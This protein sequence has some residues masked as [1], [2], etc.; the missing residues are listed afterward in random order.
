MGSRDEDMLKGRDERNVASLILVPTQERL[1]TDMLRL[2]RTITRP[3]GQTAKV[4]CVGMPGIGLARGLDNDILFA[5]INTYIDADC[6]A[7]GIIHT[8]AYALLKLAGL[9]T[10]GQHYHT[11][12]QGL[13]RMLY[14]TYHVT[15]GWFD[16]QEKRFITVAFR[17]IDSL[18]YT[19]KEQ[20]SLETNLHLDRRS[21]L[22]IRISTEVAKSIKYGYIKPLDLDIYQHLPTVGSRTLY[23]LL[24]VYL[25]EAA[26]LN[27]ITPY[28]LSIPM[29]AL[30]ENCG[31]I[32]KRTDHLRKALEAM[33]APLLSIG[34]LKCV[35][36]YGKGVKTNVLYTYSEASTPINPEYVAMLTQHG[37]HR[38]IAEK[39]VRTLGDQIVVVVEKFLDRKKNTT[40]PIQN[41]GAYLHNLLKEAASIINDQKRETLKAAE[42]QQNKE[43][44]KKAQSK[45]SEE[46]QK[47]H[48]RKREAFLQTTDL[49]A[50]FEG[51]L[52]SFHIGFLARRG[53][54]TQ[55][56]DQLRQRILDGHISGRELDKAVSQ[57]MLSSDLTNLRALL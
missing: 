49:N 1:Q 30:A 38:G 40:S 13:E 54:V 6:P 5:L 26:K 42:I 14:T 27:T 47:E 46:A 35:D 55:E 41:P 39:F 43:V 57:A 37:L 32:G 33:H 22:S 17:V 3:N 19:H 53:L 18:A 8:S 29:M 21:T 52:T 4:V 56:V 28:Q 12:S 51:I 45:A 24:D 2:E 34:Y 9:D 48:D 7:D 23:R 20:E 25:N 10:G 31:L 16:S 50:L 15:D 44:I 36:F 11:L